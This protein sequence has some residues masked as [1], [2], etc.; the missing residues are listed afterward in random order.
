MDG[1]T[2]DPLMTT[3]GGDGCMRPPHHCRRV[4]AP[5]RTH[6]S[7]SRRSLMRHTV[8]R[9]ISLSAPGLRHDGDGDD[10][11]GWCP[12]S[13]R[14]GDEIWEQETRK[15]TG[16]L[17]HLIG[18]RR[19]GGDALLVMDQ[20]GSTADKTPTVFTERT[21]WLW[22]MASSE[23][24]GRD[25]GGLFGRVIRS[26]LCAE[27]AGGFQW[28]DGMRFLFLFANTQRRKTV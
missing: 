23:E 26:G 17:P 10:T 9:T 12:G 6:R 2:L 3:Q 25:S 15:V 7:T 21:G 18:G 24:C 20:I 11:Q 5:S 1:V 4:R 27:D 13:K 22:L 28:A 19:N 16:V 14:R 8:C